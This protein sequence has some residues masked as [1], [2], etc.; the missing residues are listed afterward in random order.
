MT[1]NASH[2]PSS[3]FEQAAKVFDGWVDPETSLRV[4]RVHRHADP[5]EHEN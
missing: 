3:I 4:L 5:P 2:G 1:T